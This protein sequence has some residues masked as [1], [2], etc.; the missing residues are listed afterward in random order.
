MNPN[1]DSLHT[2]NEIRN[3]MERS[4]KFLS[5]SGLSGVFA[6]IFAL[7]GAAAAYIRFK[8]DWLAD[9]LV[10]MGTYQGHSRADIIGFL[11]VD[12]ICVLVASLAVGII[13]T[14][15][16]GRRNGLSVWNGSSKRLLV[17][18]LI[19]LA[20]G[21]IFCLAMLSYGFI[22]LVFPVTLL[23]Y[24]LALVNA[25]RFTYPEVFYMGISEIGIGCVALFLTGYS[26][27]F[28][29]IGF[30]LL[31]IVYGL[32]M[33]NRY[34]REKLPN[35]EE[36]GGQRQGGEFPRG[37]S[38]IVGMLIL[39][40]TGS[41]CSAQVRVPSDSMAFKARKWYDKETIYL[42]NGNSFVKNNVIYS[43]QKAIRNEFMVSP[44]GLGLYLKSRRTRSIGLVISLAG[45]AGSIIS[46]ISGNRDNL[47][48]FFWVSVGTGLV[49]SGFTMAA[50]NQRDQA[51]WIRNRDAMLFLEA[52]Q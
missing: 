6:G 49:G 19:P 32:T 15:R 40:L 33:Y 42:R 27:I 22:W 24:G 30:G 47:K 23:F 41:V 13:L 20:T 48:T 38:G 2:L 31:H 21:G 26:L 25:S 17:A 44:E 50:N 8:T 34:E 16:K 36:P 39:L 3:L 37:K 18:M 4:S 14:V 46:L 5:L 29:A 52:N 12:G 35:G 7:I 9:I 11:L 28:W 43:G 1:Q 45:S 10:P 51:V